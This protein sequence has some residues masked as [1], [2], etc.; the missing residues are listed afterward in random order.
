MK[1]FILFLIVAGFTNTYAQQPKTGPELFESKCARC[2]G[3]DGTKGRWGAIN[4]K[5]SYISDAELFATISNGR[6]FMPTWKN[7]LTPEQIKK[8][9]AYVKSLR[10]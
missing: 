9:G 5:Y 7:K 8:V 3:S 2:H 6:R 4:L 1:P 10:K